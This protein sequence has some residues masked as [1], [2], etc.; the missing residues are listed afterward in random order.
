MEAALVEFPIKIIALR[1]T[2]TLQCRDNGHAVQTG[3]RLGTSKLRGRRQEIPKRPNFIAHLRGLDGARPA[4]K[5][6]DANA[7]LVQIAL[8]TTQRS[9]AVEEFWMIAALAMRSVVAGENHEG[10]LLNALLAAFGQQ[11][12]NI[13]IEPR[14]HSGEILVRLRPGTLAIPSVAG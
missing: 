1:Q 12:S 11:A 3:R 8:N 5:R 4:S 9:I 2:T 7:A 14:H 6:W 13:A 10:I